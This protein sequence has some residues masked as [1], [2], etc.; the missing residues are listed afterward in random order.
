ME[1]G[2]YHHKGGFRHRLADAQKEKK[3]WRYH[4]FIS[5]GNSP[6]CAFTLLFMYTL[7]VRPSTF[8]V[9]VWLLVCMMY[10]LYEHMLC[11]KDASPAAYL[12]N[13]DAR[14][15]V[16]STVNSASAHKPLIWNTAVMR[17]IHS[18]HIWVMCTA[19]L[20]QAKVIII[21]RQCVQ[22]I[23]V[24]LPEKDKWEKTGLWPPYKFS[25]I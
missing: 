13:R 1:A 11:H 21:S 2:L 15:Y 22:K 7:H 24:Y 4:C 12:H 8:Y 25:K 17:H 9:H 16:L 14:D 5:A 19:S 23:N 3:N 6:L 10:T 18:S 20:Q